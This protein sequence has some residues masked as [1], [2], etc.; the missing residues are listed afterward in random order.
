MEIKSYVLIPPLP[1]LK[2]G[3][4]FDYWNKKVSQIS[5]DWYLRDWNREPILD[6]YLPERR[7]FQAMQLKT[8]SYGFTKNLG[9][10]ETARLDLMAELDADDD[11]KEVLIFIKS[12]VHEQ[13]EKAVEKKL[14]PL[15]F[16]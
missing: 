14:D 16:G 9:N 11:P 15:P 10:Y 6:H 8:I 12:F 13:L 3:Y 1:R 2:A 5:N 4:G 7:D